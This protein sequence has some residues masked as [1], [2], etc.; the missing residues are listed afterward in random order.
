MWK[1]LQHEIR[2][3]IDIAKILAIELTQRLATL[4]VINTIII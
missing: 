3:E 2:P 1:H 4:T